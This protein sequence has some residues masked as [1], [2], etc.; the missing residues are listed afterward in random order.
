MFER[1]TQAART[2]VVLA[3]EEAR[4]LRHDFVGTEHLLLGLLHQPAEPGVDVLVRHGLDLRTAR[5]AVQR[6]LDDGR[7]GLDAEALEAIG[8]DLEAVTARV[9]ATFGAGALSAPPTSGGGRSGGRGGLRGGAG[10]LPFT[11]RAKKAMALSV[12]AA[13]GRKD[14]HIGTR[15]LLLGLIREGGGLAVVVL[16]EHGLDLA[17][18]ERAVE[19]TGGAA[20]N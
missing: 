2:S 17:E 1:F 7:S 13:Q 11:G 20:P 19:S 18:V 14:G 8:I 6:L 16:R 10:W 12:R 15:H 3:T 9:E 4:G 5:A